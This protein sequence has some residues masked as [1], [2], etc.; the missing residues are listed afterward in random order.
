MPKTVIINVNG[1]MDFVNLIS[2]FAVQVNH[3]FHI[4][5]PVTAKSHAF[6]LLDL[7]GEME[8]KVILED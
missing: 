1:I 5:T 2:L 8:E 3:P 6:V 7:H 4:Y